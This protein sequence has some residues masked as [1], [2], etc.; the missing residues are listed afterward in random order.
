MAGKVS[1]MEA[2]YPLLTL[3]SIVVFVWLG[4]RLALARNRNAWGWALAGAVLPPL[5]L[6]LLVLKPLAPEDNA[7]AEDA[8]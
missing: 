6:I 4:R 5:L 2:F 3:I 7:D 1:H 8:L